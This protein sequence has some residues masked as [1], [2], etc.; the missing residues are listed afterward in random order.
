MVKII[1]HSLCLF[2]LTVK[3]VCVPTGNPADPNLIG[4]DLY[5]AY[6]YRFARAAVKRYKSVTKLWQIE[7]E[8][9]E[10][11]LACLAGQRYLNLSSANV[12]KQMDF[13]TTLL[14]VEYFLDV[15]LLS[16]FVLCSLWG[17]FG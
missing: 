7:N 11:F 9:N 17:F 15:T 10:A 3:T 13:L 8:L 4:V 2:P 12:W 6:Q 14:Q 1:N 16:A 5:L